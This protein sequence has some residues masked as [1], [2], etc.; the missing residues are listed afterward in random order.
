M[1]ATDRGLCYAVV[2]E[3]ED[4]PRSQSS[5]SS[6]RISDVSVTVHW[7]QADCAGVYY[8]F[9]EQCDVTLAHPSCILHVVEVEL[10]YSAT[11]HRYEL[12]GSSVPTE[13]QVSVYEG[14]VRALADPP[15]LSNSGSLHVSTPKVM[16]QHSSLSEERVRKKFKDVKTW[17]QI[18]G[19]WEYELL[20]SA[21]KVGGYAAVFYECTDNSAKVFL[22]IGKVVSVQP[23][24]DPVSVCVKPMLPVYPVSCFQAA[25]AM[26]SCKWGRAQGH[27]R[28][29]EIIQHKDVLMYFPAMNTGGKL[30]QAVADRL[31]HLGIPD[32]LGRNA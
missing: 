32:K 7:V 11:E 23:E 18:D 8:R 31:Q 14:E 29:E 4:A 24:Q 28:K 19:R 21:A 5:S 9:A 27:E 2:K 25:C 16:G 10:E 20:V 3:G 6:V 17:T 1:S 22:S 26:A 30:P 13:T 15:S 12:A